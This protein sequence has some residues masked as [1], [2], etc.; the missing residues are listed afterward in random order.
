MKRKMYASCRRYEGVPDVAAATKKVNEVFV[1]LISALPG[2]IE[3]HWISL[4]NNAMMSF[5]VFKTYANA[6]NANVKASVWVREHLRS[7]LG[8]SVRTEAG[9]ILLYS[10]CDKD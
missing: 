4:G 8:P 9:E 1:P 2:F 6:V 5:T 3:Y 10:G 7:V